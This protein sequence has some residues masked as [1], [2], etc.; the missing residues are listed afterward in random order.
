VNA[1]N[2]K[3]R[4]E[5][6]Q[7]VNAKALEFEATPPQDRSS[8]ARD[9]P[10][11]TDVHQLV[12]RIVE[13]LLYQSEIEAE[14][15]AQVVVE[16]A[17]VALARFQY[18]SQF[19]TWLFKI[20]IRTVADFRR[21][22]RNNVISLQDLSANG[23]DGEQQVPEPS[24]PTVDIIT[25]ITVEQKLRMLSPEDADII[26]RWWR[27]ESPELIGRRLGMHADTIRQRISRALRRLAKIRQQEKHVELRRTSRRPP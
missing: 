11:W 3:S 21:G 23:H 20:V 4:D 19:T 12:L 6:H 24:A 13:P 15:V 17:W 16:K 25:V 22:I 1:R 8:L 18:K 26:K 10:F 7:S 2:R 5:L 14:D 27:R 9:D